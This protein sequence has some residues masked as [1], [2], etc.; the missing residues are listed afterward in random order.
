MFRAHKEE[1]SLISW[2]EPWDN[3]LHSQIFF[4]DPPVFKM[5]RFW[6]KHLSKPGKLIRS[7]SVVESFK[8]AYKVASLRAF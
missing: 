6:L 1:G 2:A 7:L 5:C 8:E 4:V 3:S